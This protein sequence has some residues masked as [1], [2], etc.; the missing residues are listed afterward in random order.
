MTDMLF[1]SILNVSFSCGLIVIVLIL[2]SSFLDKRYAAKWKCL[3]WIFIAVR[4]LLPFNTETVRYA[5]NFITKNVYT[6]QHDAVASGEGKE[7]AA[8][9]RLVIELPS[10]ISTPIAS[11]DVDDQVLT[12][13]DIMKF[14]WLT[15]TL[16]FLGVHIGSYLYYKKQLIKHSVPVKNIAQNRY[17]FKQ[18]AKLYK[19]LQIDHKRKIPVRQSSISDSPMIIGFFNPSLILPKADYEKEELYFILK[20]E[21]IHLKRCDVCQKFLLVAANALHWFNPLI[22]FMRREAFVDIELS[23]DERVVLGEDYDTKKVYTEILYATLYKK[24]NRNLL[25]STQ[26]SGNTKIMKK[27]FRNLL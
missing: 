19:E 24:R 5:V 1:L 15:G 17:I 25:I 14:I 4:L 22:W 27:R 21:L 7:T 9:I 23:C 6:V 11:Q 8:P 2:F 20:H 16:G 26:F 3:I 12:P 10:T 18:I 13:I